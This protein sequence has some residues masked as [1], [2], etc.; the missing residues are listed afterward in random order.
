MDSMD[1]MSSELVKCFISKITKAFLIIFHTHAHSFQKHIMPIWQSW[2]WVF[3]FFSYSLSPYLFC[4][5]LSVSLSLALTRACSV[6]LA[7]YLI[8]SF[9]LPLS[10]LPPLVL[11]LSLSL[12]CLFIS[13]SVRHR[14]GEAAGICLYA[15]GQGEAETAEEAAPAA[16]QEPPVAQHAPAPRRPRGSQGE[17]V[18][19]TCQHMSSKIQEI[20]L[21]G[22]LGTMDKTY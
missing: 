16:L 3:T 14:V 12:I 22:G 2:I 17:T 21:Q 15:G 20:L 11:P 4:L 10:L 1:K 8:F 7:L 19:L 18:V 5:C 9:V 13:L 6:S